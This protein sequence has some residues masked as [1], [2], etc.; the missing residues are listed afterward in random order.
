MAWKRLD[1]LSKRQFTSRG[2]GPRVAA[3]LLCTKAEELYPDI[4][5]AISVKQ[6]VLNIYVAPEHRLDFHLIEGELLK[7]LNSYAQ[8][9]KL[10]SVTRVRLTNQPPSPIL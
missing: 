1:L 8:A 2:L 10:P 6:R 5:R 7:Q 4:L 3:G 9:A